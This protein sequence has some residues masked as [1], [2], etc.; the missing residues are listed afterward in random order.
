MLAAHA[1]GRELFVVGRS[2]RRMIEAAREVGY[3]KAVPPIR[4][5]REA[6]SLPRNRVLYL[7]TG[8]QGEAAERAVPR[9]PA[10]ST[11]GC[12]SSPATP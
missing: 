8:S 5:E 6:D 4:D 10:A 2:M 1:A 9:S 12:G 7:C 3:L 11:R